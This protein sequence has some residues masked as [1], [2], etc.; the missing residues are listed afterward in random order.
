[1]KEQPPL[2]KML[3]RREVIVLGVSG[4]ITGAAIG[5]DYYRRRIKPERE[6]NHKVDQ[7]KKAVEEHAIFQQ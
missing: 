2:P 3:N 1:M 4:A 6:A 5:L 7:K